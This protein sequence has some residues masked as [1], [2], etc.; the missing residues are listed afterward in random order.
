[1]GTA[2]LSVRSRP[3]RALMG[4]EV[5]RVVYEI[6]EKSIIVLSYSRSMCPVASRKRLIS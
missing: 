1:M 6:R 2:L 3:G 5:A 4:G